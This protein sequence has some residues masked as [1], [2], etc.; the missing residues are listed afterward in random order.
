MSIRGLSLGL[1]LTA[2]ALAGCTADVGITQDEIIER[3]GAFDTSGEFTRVD[4]TPFA[5][6][7][8]AETVSVW[9]SSEGLQTYL[10]ID[11]DDTTATVP[12]GFPTGTIIIKEM[13]DATGTRSMLTVMAKG[14]EGGEPTTADW[15]WGRF[16]PDG[17]LAEGGSVGYCIDC[18]RGNQLER[19]D[20]VRGVALSD[21]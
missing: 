20:W 16:L 9:V 14:G 18:H 2:I 12:A 8:Q 10:D 5:S 1:V 3:V 7:H 19:T 6:Q 13:F 15:W 11:P 17:T 21:R 4:A